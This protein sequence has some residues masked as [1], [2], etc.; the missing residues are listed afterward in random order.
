MAVSK[1]SEQ[2]KANICA[3][4]A[5]MGDDRAVATKHA[6]KL[7]T[8]KKWKTEAWFK[9]LLTDIQEHNTTQLVAKA[10]RAMD[11]ALDELED[12]IDRGDMRCVLKGENV[13]SYREPV[14]ARDLSAI[15]NVLATRS[16]KAAALSS[17]QVSN[18]QLADLQTSFRQFAKS[19]RAKQVG[20][21]ETIDGAL[22]VETELSASEDV[23]AINGANG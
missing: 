18:Y 5:I 10:H 7:T 20:D 23:R 8:L 19:Y 4:W 21:I 16:E 17:Q 6:V 11:K 1:Y 12:R 13:V 22:T 15:V 3:D 14:R 9:D 2:E